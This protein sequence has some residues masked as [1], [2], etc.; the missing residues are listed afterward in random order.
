[1]GGALDAVGGTANFYRRMG[2]I[3][4]EPGET[5]TSEMAL[6]PEVARDFLDDVTGEQ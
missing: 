3:E 2:F 4:T 1:M 6:T 5:I